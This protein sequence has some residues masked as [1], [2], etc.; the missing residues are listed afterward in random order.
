MKQTLLSSFVVISSIVYGLYV[1]LGT[2]V[3]G[4]PAATVPIA[5]TQ[6]VTGTTAAIAPVPT[7]GAAPAAQPS[8]PR[9]TAPTPAPVAKPKGQYA[10]GT[11]TGSA[12]DAYYGYVQVQVTVAGGKITNVAFLQYPSDRS[13][14]RYINSQATPMLASEAISAQNANV[15]I[16][17]GATDTSMAFQQSLAS[18]LVQA[19][20]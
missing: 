6:Q 13:T 18:A 5:S 1:T 19:K 11:Y 10:D 15:N 2:P 8:P 3:S 14:S 7:S 17:S 16:I 9:T 12:A 20:A 4:V